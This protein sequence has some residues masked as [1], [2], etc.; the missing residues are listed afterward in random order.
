M[1]QAKLCRE[2]REQRVQ[3]E[4]Y[5]AV[6][7]ALPRGQTFNRLW[8]ANAY[9][10][11]FPEQFAHIGFLTAEEAQRLHRLLHI[12]PGEVLAAVNAKEAVAD[13]PAPPL[14]AASRSR[15]KTGFVTPVGRWIREAAGAAQ[16]VDF[17]AASRGWALRV[18]QTGWTTGLQPA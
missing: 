12:R 17:S 18:W 15:A 9:H 10:G 8:R 14:P 1:L 6:Y 16:D 7:D 4:G 3:L 13:I 5:D 11:D 2:L